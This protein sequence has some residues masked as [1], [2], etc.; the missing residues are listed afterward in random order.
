LTTARSLAEQQGDTDTYLMATVQISQLLSARDASAG[1]AELEAVEDQAAEMSS[2]TA[3]QVLHAL[4]LAE[5]AEDPARAV[6]HLERA[7]RVYRDA[8]DA[9]SEVTALGDLAH[10]RQRLGAGREATDGLEEAIARA[11]GLGDEPLVAGL[12]VNLGMLWY[13]GGEPACVGAFEEA[14]DLYRVGGSIDGEGIALRNLLASQQRFEAPGAITDTARRL[15]ALRLDDRRR[16]RDH[17]L[18]VSAFWEEGLLEEA[19]SMARRAAILDARLSR[20]PEI[21]AAAISTVGGTG[22]SARSSDQQ[23]DPVLADLLEL[24][25]DA[26]LTQGA[27]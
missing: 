4:A 15:V 25:S 27:S 23:P 7:G 19:L 26:P 10:F 16:A 20:A 14:A 3:A 2:R 5:G 18:A 22:A 6:A 8:G 1:M 12:L 21:L 13:S 24:L 17:V 9:Y 11:R